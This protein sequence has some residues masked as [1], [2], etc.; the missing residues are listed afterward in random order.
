MRVKGGGVN[1]GSHS[2][3]VTDES[4]WKGRTSDPRRDFQEPP[5]PYQHAEGGFTGLWKRTMQTVKRNGKKK[6]SKLE[7]SLIFFIGALF[8]RYNPHQ[9]KEKRKRSSPSKNRRVWGSRQVFS[10]TRTVCLRRGDGPKAD[11]RS[12]T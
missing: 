11:P 9:K 10:F 2:V 5:A 3:D 6:Y 4:S 1:K 7:I 8:P 12:T